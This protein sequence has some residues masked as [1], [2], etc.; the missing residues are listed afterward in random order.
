MTET[1][2]KA[3]E[4]A[5]AKARFNL[6]QKASELHDLIEDRLPA[7]YAEIMTMAENTHKACYDWD[8]LNK[9]LQNEKLKL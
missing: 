8:V 5:V 2:L 3:L 4:K 7:D 9:Q 6:S 1:E